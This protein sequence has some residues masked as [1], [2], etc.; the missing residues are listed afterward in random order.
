MSS[1][2]VVMLVLA[3][4]LG[5]QFTYYAILYHGQRQQAEIK[6]RLH[7]LADAGDGQGGS[8][9]RERRIARNRTLARMLEGVPGATGLEALLLQTDLPWTVARVY[10]LS[11]GG[12]AVAAFAAIVFAHNVALALL[13]A[14][15]VASIPLVSVLESRAKRS[16]KLSAQLPDALDMMVRSLR[17]GH[18]I[19]AAMRLVAE[20]MPLP[21]AVE[22]G[23]C[24]EEQ[25][26]GVPLK[27]AVRNLATRVPTNLDLKIFAVSVIIQHDTGGNLVEILE[28]IADTVRERFKFYGKLRALTTEAKLSGVILSVLPFVAVALVL[29]LRP[30]Y[31]QPLIEDSL[32]HL[33][34]GVGVALWALGGLWMRRL[35]RV[36]Y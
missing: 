2:V 32:G 16:H 26:L 19:S 21:V 14:A 27:D 4:L 34:L 13:G 25:R 22:F 9:L 10:A 31:L 36:D 8:V 7:L 18:G 30:T 28:R 1:V 5:A 12:G 29:I 20:E 33:L 24:F 35:S 3:A 15:A 11:L 23:R 17:A 6:R